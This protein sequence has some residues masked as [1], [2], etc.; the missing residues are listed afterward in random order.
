MG[1]FSLWA[2][3]DMLV[4]CSRCSCGPFW[5]LPWAILDILKIYELF[6]SESFW[7]MGRFGIDPSVI[8]S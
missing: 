4:G 3:W 2:V 5:I 7:F 8:I 6:W 1:W